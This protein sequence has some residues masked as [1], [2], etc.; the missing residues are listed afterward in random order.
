MR[1]PAVLARND[2]FATREE[3]RRAGFSNYVI[4]AELAR[5]T[6]IAYGR[7]VV[8]TPTANP[9]FTRAARMRARVACV[10]AARAMGLWVLDQD[11]FHVTPRSRNGRFRADGTSPAAVLHWSAAPIE[12]DVHRL[13]SESGRNALAHIAQCQ[14]RDVAA[15]TF[16]SAV[17]K[18]LISLD[19]LAALASGHRGRFAMAPRSSRATPTLDSRR[20]RGCG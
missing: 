9:A 4:R 12:T 17:R 1:L 16:D 2:G 14:P 5:G 7:D 19:E 3:L 20:S 18:G 10:T 11:E 8:G 15:A 6:L 13:V